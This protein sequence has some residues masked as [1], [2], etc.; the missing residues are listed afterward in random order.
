MDEGLL[1]EGIEVRFTDFS[2]STYFA[3]LAYRIDNAY[4]SAVAILILNYISRFKY[5][6]F[7][8]KLLLF[9]ST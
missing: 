2:L 3:F 8:W 1:Q 9:L 4:M 5:C 6:I 7:K